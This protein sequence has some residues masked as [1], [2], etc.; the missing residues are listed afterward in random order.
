[1]AGETDGRPHLLIFE[2]KGDY[3]AQTEDTQYKR[4]VLR[5]LEAAF[6]PARAVNEDGAH[7]ATSRSA[8][9]RCAVHSS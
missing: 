3:L 2:T 9:A 1:M 7:T 6:N 5:T 4:D 8:T